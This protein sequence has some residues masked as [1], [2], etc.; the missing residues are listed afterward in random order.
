[1]ERP[2]K[3]SGAGSAELGD[4]ACF[5]KDAP[6]LPSAEGERSSPDYT[7]CGASSPFLT[8]QKNPRR[9]VYSACRLEP[10]WGLHRKVVMF[11]VRL[12]LAFVLWSVLVSTVSAQQELGKFQKQLE[13]LHRDQY[14]RID[15]SIPPERR[16]VFDY[17]AYV[18]FSYLS[19][20]DQNNDNHVLRQTE[21][22]GYARLNIDNVHEIFLRGHTGYQD[23]ND[24]DSFDG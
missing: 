4:P 3:G 17:G 8:R 12:F 20:D 21:V 14:L 16:A 9:C 2:G 15:Q 11:R 24:K 23:F 1:T 7:H 5:T 13:Q 22:T 6:I 18:T 19:V 10:A